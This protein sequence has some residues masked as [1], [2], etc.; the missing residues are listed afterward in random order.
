VSPGL[1]FQKKGAR[2]MGSI[3]S[4]PFVQFAFGLIL[5]AF[6]INLLIGAFY[7]PPIGQSTDAIISYIVLCI[8]ALLTIRGAIITTKWILKND[9][10]E[11]FTII[12][13]VLISFSSIT[14][15][16]GL[17]LSYA[18]RRLDDEIYGIILIGA[19]ILIAIS[20]IS[21]GLAF[22]SW[23]RRGGTGI[24]GTDSPPRDQ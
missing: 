23:R 1:L 9:S 10:F 20:L 16:L 5:C 14:L 6:G 11:S 19:G 7:L 17:I 3:F 22:V 24:S 15:I 4:H 8:G 21:A 12:E 2:A 13:K 18:A